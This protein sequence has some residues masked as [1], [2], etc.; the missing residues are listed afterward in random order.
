MHAFV[1]LMPITYYTFL[2]IYEK[3]IQYCHC[4]E[5]QTSPYLQLVYQYTMFKT[6]Q[7]RCRQKVTTSINSKV[8][9]MMVDSFILPKMLMF[10]LFLSVTS[11]P[12]VTNWATLLSKFGPSCRTEVESKQR[13][14]V[15]FTRTF[16]RR[17]NV[18]PIISS[19]ANTP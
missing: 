3:H 10:R 14:E 7:S 19:D 12:S 18:S 16:R 4:M 8:C 11:K 9:D 13:H 5:G 17:E 6:E 2:F 15:S 1:S